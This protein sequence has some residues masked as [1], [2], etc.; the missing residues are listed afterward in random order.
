MFNT[1]VWTAFGNHDMLTAK[2]VHQRGPF[3][4]AFDSQGSGRGG[5]PG[6][7]PSQSAAYYR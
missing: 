1:P 2:G 7:A 4:Y 5:G 6:S 3:Y